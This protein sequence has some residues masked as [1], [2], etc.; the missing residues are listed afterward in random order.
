ASQI[1]LREDI[2]NAVRDKKFHI[3]AMQS[4]E[5]A[6]ALFTGMPVKT[7]YERVMK[8]LEAYDQILAERNLKAD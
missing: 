3:Y 6:L 8:Q 4:V 1:I 7:L 2:A 5:D